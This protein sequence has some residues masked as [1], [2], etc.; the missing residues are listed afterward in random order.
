[1]DDESQ[2]P[3]VGG[4]II[5]VGIACTWVVFLYFIKKAQRCYKEDT[6]KGARFY[7]EENFLSDEFIYNVI[8]QTGYE[9]ES[10]TCS[11]VALRIVGDAAS[12]LTYMLR[13]GLEQYLLTTGSRIGICI[14]SCFDVGRVQAIVFEVDPRFP[15]S[16]WKV[17]RVDLWD[18]VHARHYVFVIDRVVLFSQRL[19][20]RVSP[21]GSHGQNF[22]EVPVSVRFARTLR[23]FHLPLSVVDF[24]YG[25]RYS[26]VQR[27][28]SVMAIGVD[29]M[30][31][32]CAL[33]DWCPENGGSGVN[34]VAVLHSSVYLTAIVFA[35]TLL[36]T[37]AF[38]FC[39]QDVDRDQW[40]RPADIDRFCKTSKSTRG[41]TPRA[42]STRDPSFRYVRN[43][44]IGVHSDAAS[45]CS[46]TT[47]LS[48][49]PTIDAAAFMAHADGLRLRRC[50]PPSWP[51]C[52]LPWTLVGTSML[53]S[54][55]LVCVCAACY[56]V[57]TCLSWL[58]TL[59]AAGAL[60]CFVVEPA[61]ALLI[62]FVFRDF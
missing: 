47:N 32:D 9:P 2:M 19:S 39:Y 41:G 62:A 1:M 40:T 11:T 42:D 20:E 58:L 55:P 51:A 29:A 34:L 3:Y 35:C 25:S 50:Y 61:K 15:R 18:E 26:R 60:T 57:G 59:A 22:T 36:I 13:H 44:D 53:V 10:G 24:P 23:L 27:L 7:S 45:L 17:D 49:Q 33:H 6:L 5:P 12:T 37:F 38:E 30:L 16:N 28:A 56:D 46:R 4:Y 14:T 48:P 8:I 21:V 43:Q 54:T 52:L 31:V